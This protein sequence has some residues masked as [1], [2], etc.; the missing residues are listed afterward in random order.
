MEEGK[1]AQ[2]F[3]LD[4]SKLWALVRAARGR[5][6]VLGLEEPPFDSEAAVQRLHDEMKAYGLDWTLEQH[7][8]L[9]VEPDPTN[10]YWAL[11]PAL[12]DCQARGETREEAKAKLVEQIRERLQELRSQ[13]KPLPVERGAVELLPV[14]QCL[15]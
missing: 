13:G 15:P 10:G 5:R 14:S 4:D 1:N 11:C 3:E 2:R 9:V 6:E 7:Y 12:G 8:I